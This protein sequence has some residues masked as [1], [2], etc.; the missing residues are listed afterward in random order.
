MLRVAEERLELPKELS[1]AV[2]AYLVKQYRA[3]SKRK[4]GR[5]ILQK[6]C[7]F[8]K[9]SGVPLPL[10]FEIYHY[11]PFCQ[12]IFDITDNLLVDDVIE[13]ESTESSQSDYVPGPNCDF[14]LREFHGEI[15]KQKRRLDIV[16]ETFSLLD[17][18]SF[19]LVSTIHYIYSSSSQWNKKPPRKKDVTAAV[20]EIKGHKFGRDFIDKVYEILLK[21]GL[22]V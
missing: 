8:A 1:H 2:I 3:V 15:E 7:Y 12:E 11:G 10:R 22:L 17:P 21:A 9:A 5:T 20:F 4:L 16:A 19:E 6:L 18:S 13:D 14:L